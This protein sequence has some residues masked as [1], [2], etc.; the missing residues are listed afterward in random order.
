VALAA[1]LLAGCGG[2]G[3]GED[4]AQGLTP[5]QLL[6][7]S[8]AAAE[9]AG[10][11]RIAL[12]ATGQID[13]ADASAVPGGN[14]L[15]GPLG[16][17][18]EGP[19]DPPDKAS[20]DASIELSGLPLQINI[21]RVGDE[22]FVGALGQDFRV[23]LP[24]EQVALLDLGSLYPT[25]VDWVASPVE[26]GREEVDGTDTVK[27]SGEIDPVR[28]LSS[29]APLLGGEAPPA[30]R[31]RAALREGTVEAWIGTEDLLPRRVH[32][33][34]DADAARVAEGVGQVSIDLTADMSAW[35]EPVDIAAPANP[36]ELDTDQLGGLF[37]G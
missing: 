30:A 6:D 34:L 2:D 18:G 16:I 28:A 5:A 15:N 29:L 31:A 32:L 21:T 12:E 24:P 17:S 7:Q 1:G 11:F 33:V 10:P 36:R 22:V 26:D 35:G 25:L 14:L 23:D 19:V 3:D 20:I 8:A 9:E 13:V 27:V 37:G 4:R